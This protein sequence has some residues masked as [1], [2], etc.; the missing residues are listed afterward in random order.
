MYVLPF[1]LA[2]F[3]LSVAL[4]WRLP[5]RGS[6]D[7]A[8]GVTG[9]ELGGDDVEST[10]ASGSGSPPFVSTGGVTG[11]TSL[12]SSVGSSRVSSCSFRHFSSSV[13][14]RSGRSSSR[15]K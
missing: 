1:V 12:D 10:T 4:R 11:F 15:R 13:E 9:V 6:F 3:I 5:L 7:D 2:I 8:A 14:S